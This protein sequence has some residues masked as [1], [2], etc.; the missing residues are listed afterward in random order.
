VMMSV[1]GAFYYLRV[2]KV[3][4]FDQP[5]DNTPLHAGADVRVLLSMNGLA[6]AGLGLMPQALMSLCAYA[7]LGSL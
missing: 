4:Y 1:I 2:V 3:M 7:L 6:I 5:A